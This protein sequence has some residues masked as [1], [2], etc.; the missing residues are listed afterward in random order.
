MRYI[1]YIFILQVLSITL[2]AQTLTENL[3]GK[4]SFISSQNVY[5]RFKSTEGISAGDTLF[6]L[7][8][9]K[10]TAV[11]IVSNLS[12]SSCVCTPL[13]A[14]NMSVS[15]DIVARTKSKAV[16]PGTGV[17]T[18]V[19]EVPVQ[20]IPADSTKKQVYPGQLKHKINGSVSVYSYSDYSNTGA[21]N[22]TQLR[23]NYTL[24]ALNIGNSKFSIENYI[25]FRHKLGDWSAVK[26]RLV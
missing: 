18:A 3:Q 20:V 17:E 24:N 10:L 13:T 25:T 21:K 26:K 15:Q 1:L 8:G 22:S 6:T 2:E 4:V 23:Y 14:I 9:G 16:R 19:K 12:S 11:M 7:S 5:V